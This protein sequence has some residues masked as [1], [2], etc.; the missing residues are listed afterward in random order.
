[1]RNRKGTQDPVVF[2]P[3]EMATNAAF[4]A[5]DVT[6]EV[7]LESLRVECEDDKA[8]ELRPDEQ[9]S[10]GPENAEDGTSNCPRRC[11]IRVSVYSV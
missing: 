8:G 11:G 10:G 9:H 2:N 6:A 7:N 4:D 3:V 1:M 5:D